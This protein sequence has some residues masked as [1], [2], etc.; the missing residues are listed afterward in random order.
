MSLLPLEKYLPANTLPFIQKW[1][2]P[3]LTN[4][5]IKRDRK[6]KLGDYRKMPNNTHQITVNGN[7]EPELFFFV[8][9]HEIAHLLAFEKYGRRI[10]PHGREWKHTYSV[11]LSETISLYSKELQPLIIQYAHSPKANYMS[12]TALVKYFNHRN[13]SLFLENI[14]IGEQFLFRNERY[15]VIKKL[16]KNYLCQS[17]DSGLKYRIHPL[18]EVEKTK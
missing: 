4:I 7:L 14:N 1:L 17:L 6:S 10:T 5:G 2:K 16:K 15:T 9:T 13:V 3:H 18:A 11:L 8:L 12:N